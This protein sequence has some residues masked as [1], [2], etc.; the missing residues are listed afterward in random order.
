M[1][2]DVLGA[3]AK[4]PAALKTSSGDF[5]AAGNAS[6][7]FGNVREFSGTLRECSGMLRECSG[8][9]RECFGMFGGDRKNLEAMPAVFSLPSRLKQLCLKLS[10]RH[11]LFCSHDRPYRPNHRETPAIALK[12]PSGKI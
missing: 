3:I 4:I 7:M 1:F 10:N 2:G 8:T 6:G 11:N 12:V 9:L 5:M